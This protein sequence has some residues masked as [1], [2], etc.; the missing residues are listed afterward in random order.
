MAKKQ[1]WNDDYWLLVMQLYLRKPVGLKPLYS[2]ELVEL[3]IELHIPPQ[4]L[5]QRQCDIA[6][7][8]TPRIERIWRD[9][10]ANPKRLSRAVRLLR[11]MKGFNSSGD[12]Y[13]GVAVEETF[14]LDFRPLPEDERLMPCMLVLMLDLYFR[15]TPATM[16]AE[17][18][19]IQEL[20]QLINVPAGLI[21]EVL[22]VYQYL[23]PYLRRPKQPDSALVEPCR[24]TWKR[25]ASMETVQLE[26]YAAQLSDYFK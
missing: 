10:S 5:Y 19:E 13:E 1:L 25:Y 11:E 16:V 22:Q 24:Q 14:E 23:D 21:V 20:S 4:Q 6:N 26:N 2:R 8:E 18:P 17:T 9:Y 7:L 3:S 12:F 15:L